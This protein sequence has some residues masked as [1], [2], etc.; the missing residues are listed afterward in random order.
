VVVNADNADA[1]ALAMRLP[2]ERVVRFSVG[3][4]SD[5]VACDFEEQ[6]HSAAFTL[7]GR[8]VELT[9]PGRHNVANALA[10]LGAAQAAGVPLPDAI[11][12]I[13]SFTG[14]KRR[15]E[16]VGEAGGIA[17]IHDFG[18]NPDKIAATLATL[19]AFP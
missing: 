16:L 14:L 2:A 6:P 1:A 10:A 19:H 18:H 7:A 17:V 3:G 15:F 11:H 5:L 13:A 9:V 8:R 12:A 4:D